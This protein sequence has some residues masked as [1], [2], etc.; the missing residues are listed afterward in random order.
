MEDTGNETDRSEVVSNDL[1]ETGGTI[2]RDTV[3]FAF[4]TSS[5]DFESADTELLLHADGLDT[6]IS[7]GDQQISLVVW[8]TPEAIGGGG[9]DM[10]VAKYDPDTN[11][12]SYALYW[13][14]GASDEV[15]C[16]LSSAGTTVTTSTAIGGTSLSAGTGYFLACV[17]DDTD[18][19]IYLNANID[20]NGA[21]NPKT[22]SSG[23][24]NSNTEFT[25]GARDDN[26]PCCGYNDYAD[27]LIDEVGIFDVALDGTDINDI[28]DNGLVQAVS[29]PGITLYDVEVY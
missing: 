26:F 2:P 22:Y 21:D 18:I 3:N 4:G 9:N 29:T 8:F 17:Y 7:G 28:M 11:A 6:D 20:S 12:R 16:S 25:I 1:T 5:R 23:L 10:L 13:S 15:R 14:D 19:K 27:G 24:N